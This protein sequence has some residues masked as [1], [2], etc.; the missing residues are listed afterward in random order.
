MPPR[1]LRILIA[2]DEVFIR[3][4]LQEALQRPGDTVVDLAADGGQARA[5]LA[6]PGYDLLISDL[7]MPGASGMELL[8]Y[9]S[10]HRPDTQ[11]II[12]TAHGNVT[13]AVE[14]MRKGAFDF[15]TKPVDLEHLRLL[16]ERAA[17][18]VRLVRENRRLHS[19]LEG[20][21]TFRKIVR[22]SAAMQAAAT[23]AKQVA[24]SDVPVLLRGETGSG[25]DLLARAIHE[26]SR[27]ASGPFVAVNCGGFTEDLFA[28]ELFG[29]VRG[30]FTGA[31]ADRPGR[32]AL[33]D[34][35]SLFLDEV[36]EVPLKNQVELLRVLE[37]RE[38]QA[39]GDPQIRR[40]DVRI[41]AATN[42][43]LEAAVQNG[44]FREDLYYRLNVV[45]LDVPSLRDRR[46]DIPVL[47]EMFLDEACRAQGEGRKQFSPEALEHL[48]G[49]RWPGNVRQLRNLA[50]RL[51]VTCAEKLIRVEHLP[52]GSGTGDA[53]LG[54][55]TVRLGTTVESVEAELIRHTLNRVTANRRQAARIL[56]ISVRALQYKIKR[57]GIAS[58]GSDDLDAG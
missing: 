57:Y 25:K 30:A 46:E 16:V 24:L 36:G 49:H 33:A 3:E 52:G 53:A 56:G 50:Q 29:H 6:D 19:R 10:D 15:L 38:Y 58:P 2:D 54:E 35:G 18:H 27:R 5:M 34:G 28:S 20:Q 9:V 55:F 40:A 48:A 51:A 11:T 44:A 41:I 1:L 21:D 13:T 17:E 7:R 4:G 22:R 47:A 14:A 45:P 42:R 23:V 37:N 32:F 31:H 8:E 12:L 39:V 26:R 43:D